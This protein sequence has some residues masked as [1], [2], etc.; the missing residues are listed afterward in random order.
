MVERFTSVRGEE[1]FVETRQKPLATERRMPFFSCCPV[2]SCVKSLFFFL[3]GQ[4]VKLG[5]TLILS[6]AYY[7]SLNVWTRAVQYFKSLL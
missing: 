3:K 2:P 7:K 1:E 5:T 6:Q 4:V